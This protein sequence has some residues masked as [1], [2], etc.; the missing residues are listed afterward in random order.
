MRLFVSKRLSVL[1]AVFCSFWA[2]V[3]MSSCQGPAGPQG[4]QGPAGPQGPQGP[5][6]SASASAQVTNITVAT[7][8]WRSAGT[9]SPGALLQ[10]GWKTAA[11]ITQA[12][13]NSGAVLVY[14]QVSDPPSQTTW[15][16]LP[17][18]FYGTN[19]F[20]VIDCQYRLG[21]VQ[22]YINQSNTVA[23]VT[24]T[25]TLTF[26]VVAIPGTTVT[27]LAQQLNISDYQSLKTAFHLAE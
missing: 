3:M 8:E 2:V 20:Q 10:S 9:G 5:A 25:G 26:R 21:Q 27:A 19:V 22:V 14:M 7:S 18:T 13:M 6:G 17:L 4:P 24:P 23:P 16:Q 1:I 11:N 12:I 15:Q